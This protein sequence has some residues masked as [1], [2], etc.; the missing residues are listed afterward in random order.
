MGV[1]LRISNNTKIS[2]HFDGLMEST[3][4]SVKKIV[5][6]SSRIFDHLLPTKT[7]AYTVP[8][9]KLQKHSQ[10]SE[11]HLQNESFVKSIAESIN[12]PVIQK[13]SET[14]PTEQSSKAIE[15]FKE[16]YHDKFKYFANIK[17]DDNE[18]EKILN[19]LAGFGYDLEDYCDLI[20]TDTNLQLLTMINKKS[21]ELNQDEKIS[22]AHLITDIILT[23]SLICTKITTVKNKTY[24]TSIDTLNPK[25]VVLTLRQLASVQGTQILSSLISPNGTFTSSYQNLSLPQRML[26]ISLGNLSDKFRNECIKP[27]LF[28]KIF[29]RKDLEK[30]LMASSGSLEQTY[31]NTCV[32]A[33]FAQR[34]LNH[35][36]SIA[37]MIM[38]AQKISNDLTNEANKLD[39]SFKKRYVI[40]Q[41]QKLQVRFESLSTQIQNLPDDVTQE[42]IQEITK[43][44]SRNFQQF[45]LFKNIQER[46]GIPIGKL[47]GGHWLTNAVLMV[48]IILFIKIPSLLIT[49]PLSKLTKSK[50][51]E[52]LMYSPSQLLRGGSYGLY[53]N[54]YTYLSSPEKIQFLSLKNKKEIKKLTESKK[55]M[56][57]YWLE[58]FNSGVNL[59]E[60]FHVMYLKPVI[61]K[62]EKVFLLSD[63]KSDYYKKYTIDE[64]IE[65]LKSH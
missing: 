55:S 11:S 17:L 26:W 32:G 27:P 56:E 1:K 46:A 20:F 34:T 50:E 64:F 8:K 7:T 21:E 57:D 51:I 3:I 14:L 54:I 36:C 53:D 4:K 6:V 48:P 63:P 37:V 52:R 10:N 33:V 62:G 19:D 35:I 30:W 13:P 38:L 2:T 25:K 22:Q 60:S 12:K 9:D 31:L 39:D 5:E 28:S 18:L 43:E 61:I 24:R 23:S 59:K 44:W 29:H 47:V 49:V 15:H 45:T 16:V 41:L 65:F 58:T 42:Q 40:A